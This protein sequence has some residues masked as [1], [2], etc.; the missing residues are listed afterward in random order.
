MHRDTLI[1]VDIGLLLEVPKREQW[2]MLLNANKIALRR[3]L[4]LERATDHV[5]GKPKTYLMVSENLKYLGLFL[6]ITYHVPFVQIIN[7]ICTIVNTHYIY[8]KFHFPIHHHRHI[9]DGNRNLLCI[10]IFG[11]NRVRHE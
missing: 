3:W 8:N 10:S 2:K 7:K 1:D 5:P 9:F 6:V 4:R 11:I